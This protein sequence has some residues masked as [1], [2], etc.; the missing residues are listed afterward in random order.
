MTAKHDNMGNRPWKNGAKAAFAFC[1]D[2]D[3]DTIWMNKTRNIPGGELF[4]KGRSVGLYGPR[5]GATHILEILRNFQIKATFFIPGIIVERYPEVIERISADGHELG[6]HGYAHENSYGESPEA[7]MEIIEKSQNIFEKVAGMRA[8]GFRCTGPLL[9]ETKNI[10]Y[11]YD[12]TLYVSNDIDDE[13]I[14]Y[15]IV[16]ARET[17]VVRVP[18]RQELD[19]YIQTAYNHYPPIPTG[20]PAI[21]PYEDTLSNFIR[22]LEGAVRYNNAVST[23][24]HPQLSGSPGRSIIVERLCEYVTQN[25]DIWC[26]PCKDIANWWIRKETK[27]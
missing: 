22:E 26:A 5:K 4:I 16:N 11:N 27:Q 20:L 2:L 23:A 9:P 10:L 21:A 19:E 18:C 6:H 1:F 14:G 24:F 3:G 25:D 12:D 15:E 13:R 7:Q 17:H 8:V